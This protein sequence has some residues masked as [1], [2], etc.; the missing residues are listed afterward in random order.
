M[1]GR[2]GTPNTIGLMMLSLGR[3]MADHLR[4]PS[5]NKVGTARDCQAVGP[6]Q[7][8][9]VASRARIWVHGGKRG[10]RWSAQVMVSQGGQGG[11]AARTL[12]REGDPALP[13]IQGAGLPK[14]I[15]AIRL[16]VEKI[17]GNV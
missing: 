7:R 17:P 9:E 4:T 8:L 11:Q 12:P 2:L 15:C 14:L 10:Q 16:A 13:G 6:G 3:G 1:G 5:A